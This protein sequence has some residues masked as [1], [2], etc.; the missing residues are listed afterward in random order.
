MCARIVNIRARCAKREKVPLDSRGQCGTIASVA[1]LYV[2]IVANLNALQHIVKPAP[3]VEIPRAPDKGDAK[4][5]YT[6]ESKAVLELQR[7]IGNILV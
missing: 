1:A 4:K 6:T 7:G 2:W 3:L 5:Y